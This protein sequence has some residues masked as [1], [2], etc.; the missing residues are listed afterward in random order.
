MCKMCNDVQ[1]VQPSMYLKINQ[2]ILN[3]VLSP[4]KWNTLQLQYPLKIIHLIYFSLAYSHNISADKEMAGKN[5]AL[6]AP[7]GEVQGCS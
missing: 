4:R 6:L 5:G 2:K 3:Q 1:S 7:K